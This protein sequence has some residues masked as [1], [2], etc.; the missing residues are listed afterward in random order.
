MLVVCWRR[1]A[2]EVPAD[3]CVGRAFAAGV[4]DDVVDSDD[5]E[6]S[7]MFEGNSMVMEDDADVVLADCGAPLGID[8]TT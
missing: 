7:V 1:E 8:P 3:A 6:L 2:A 4:S 5:D